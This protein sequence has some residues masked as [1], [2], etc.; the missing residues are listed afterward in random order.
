M[1]IVRNHRVAIVVTVLGITA[2]SVLVV[3]I[4]GNA[5]ST[6]RANGVLRTYAA[7]PTRDRHALSIG[8]AG[9]VTAL[10]PPGARTVLL[11][12]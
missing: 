11:C 5:A 1:R 3:V 6:A 8:T 7:C 9:A 10:V 4:A 12:L 2:A